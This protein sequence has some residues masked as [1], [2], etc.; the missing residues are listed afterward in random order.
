VV[1]GWSGWARSQFFRVCWKRSTLPQVVGWPGREFFS[2][3]AEP[4]QLV[5]E[6]AA[7]AAAAGEAG[8]V[9]HAVVGERGGGVSVQV[10]GL[11]E[12]GQDDGPGDAGVRADVQRE[13]GVVV[14]PGDDLAVGAG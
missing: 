9:D 7:S 11:A 2:R 10:R 1:V 6:A 12:G 13:P 14:E 4:A 5:L 3:D 8:G